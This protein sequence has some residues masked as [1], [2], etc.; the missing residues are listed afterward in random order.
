MVDDNTANTGRGFHMTSFDHTPT[1]L[2]GP[3]EKGA[4]RQLL[5]QHWL[6]EAMD[7]PFSEWKLSYKQKRFVAYAFS[8]K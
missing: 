6:S 4:A 7:D 2:E 1:S 3:E 5:L 8:S